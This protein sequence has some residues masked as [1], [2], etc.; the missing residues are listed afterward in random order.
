MAKFISTLALAGLMGYGAYSTVDHSAISG[1]MHV[2]RV[3]QYEA[4]NP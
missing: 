2:D 1:K 4:T 3:A